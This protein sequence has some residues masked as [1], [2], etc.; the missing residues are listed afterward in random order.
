MKNWKVIHDESSKWARWIALY[1]AVN[2]V[3]DKAEEKGIPFSKV[4][5]PPLAIMKY[6]SSSEDLILRKLLKNEYNIDVCYT[7]NDQT[8]NIEDYQYSP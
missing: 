6:I 2:H 7:E 4:D 5:L 1:E 8:N 3:A